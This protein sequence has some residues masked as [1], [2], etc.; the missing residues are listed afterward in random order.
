METGKP[1]VPLNEA[2]IKTSEFEIQKNFHNWVEKHPDL[3]GFAIPNGVKSN[4]QSVNIH[5]LIGFRPGAVDYICIAPKAVL[6]IE[7][8]TE[9]GKTSSAQIKFLVAV[10]E[11]INKHKMKFLKH[12]ICR[13]SHDAVLFVKENM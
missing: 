4:S 13:S 2:S 9:T 5:K 8:K 10:I 1:K 6:L 11:L 7:F 12:R 3:I